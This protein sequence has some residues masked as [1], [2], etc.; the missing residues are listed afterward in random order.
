MR[1]ALSRLPVRPDHV[2]V[3]GKSIRTLDVPHTA[4]IHGDA[5]CYSIACASIVAK[6]TRDRVMHALAGRYPEY[7]WEHNVG[8]ATANHL[9]GIAQHGITPH[10]RRSF[11]PVAQ[12]SFDLEAP[13]DLV[14][15]QLDTA[16]LA[17]MIDQASTDLS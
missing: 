7:R 8:Y 11:L 14:G 5:R 16:A 9:R 13:A 3:D 1:R 2:V 17:Q 6:I 10:H 4:V 12:L 15:L